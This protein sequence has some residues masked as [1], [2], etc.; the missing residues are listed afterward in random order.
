MRQDVVEVAMRQMERATV[1]KSRQLRKSS[2]LMA[3][4]ARAQSSFPAYADGITPGLN[5]HL[6]GNLDD[7]SFFLRPFFPHL[8]SV[9]RTCD[10]A[11]DQHDALLVSE[12]I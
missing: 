4:V 12:L 3:E 7:M 10:A 6:G 2:T 5:V 9:I 11:S 1:K 8:H